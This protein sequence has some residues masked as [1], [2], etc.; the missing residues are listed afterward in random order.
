MDA[1]R[2]TYTP[3]IIGVISGRLDVGFN[4]TGDKPLQNQ[5]KPI[6]LKRGSVSRSAGL[7]WPGHNLSYTGLSG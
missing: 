2:M 4:A 1:C 6:L 5:S 7:N 3:L